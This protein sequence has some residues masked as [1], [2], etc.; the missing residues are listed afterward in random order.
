M[1]LALTKVLLLISLLIQGQIPGTGLLFDDAGYASSPAQSK[2]RD[3]SKSAN[4]ALEGITKVDLKPYCPQPQNQD[5][6]G[7]CVGWSV[8]YGAMS[9]THAIENG[10]EHKQK[11]ITENAYSALFI[12][13][14][15]KDRDTACNVGTYVDEAFQFIKDS[16]NLYSKLFDTD[17]KN[18]YSLP[19]PDQLDSARQNRIK[20]FK[21]LFRVYDLGSEKVNQTKLSLVQKKPV[22]I[23]M[24]LLKNF[25]FIGNRKKGGRDLYWN[26]SLD[27]D[28]GLDYLGGHAMVVVGFDDGRQAFEIMNSWGTYWG[29]EGFIWVK[30]K[31][32]GRFCKYGFNMSIEKPPERFI[33]YTGE[34]EIAHANQETRKLEPVKLKYDGRYYY[35]DKKYSQGSR[36]Q[37]ISKG[38]KAGMYLYVFSF[39]PD[40][41]LNNHFPK[42]ESAEIPSSTV[43]LKIPAPSRALQ[44]NK[45]GKDYVI[46]LYSSNPISE[47]EMKLKKFGASPI[48]DIK[49][50]LLDVFE[51]DSGN[52]PELNF[53]KSEVSFSF[54]SKKKGIIPIVLAFEVF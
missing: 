30:Y 27:Y 45:P 4:K 38:M 21:T 51:I 36:F 5:T 22:V 42:L 3:G 35:L 28:G 6:V 47:Y 20:D 11:L 19:T 41:K 9:I 43:E 2:F 54:N 1:K 46:A 53:P 44:F 32:Y 24:Q 29:N 23:G 14:Q 7:S 13:N 49:R 40:G 26:T 15:I 31:D 8:G 50:R 25:G 33:N 12:Y 39:D 37:L 52:F 48:K 18:C 16:G 10:L 34:F 17:L